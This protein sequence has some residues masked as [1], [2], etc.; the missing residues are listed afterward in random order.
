M[1]ET[2]LNQLHP[3]PQFTREAWQLLDGQWKFA[4][5][6]AGLGEVKNWQEGIEATHDILVPF[7]Y[8]TTLSGINIK[9]HHDV[10]WYE[11]TIDVT[12]DKSVLLHFEGVD[13]QATLWVNGKH[14][15]VHEG[16]YH[17]F[18]F[19][20][21]KFVTK[22]ENKVVLKVEDSKDCTQPRGKQRWLDDN[23][24]CWYVQTT[25]IW[26]SVWLEY[27]SEVHIEYVKMTP[28][29]NNQQII[30]EIELN[31]FNSKGIEVEAEITFAGEPINDVRTKFSGDTAKIVS[32]VLINGDPWSMKRWE[33]HEPNL[34]DVKFNLYKDG[35]L[36]DEVDSYFGMRKISI[37]GQKILLNDVE[38]YQ[39]SI[40]DQGY[41]LESDL[42]PP[43]VEALERDIDFMLEMGYNSV[44]KHQKIEDNRFLYLCDKKGL[45]VWSEFPAAYTFSDKAIER[46]TTEWMKILKQHYNHPSIITWV[47]FNESWGVSDI[48]NDKKQ[49]QFTESVYY[50]TKAFD[51]MRPVV[52]NDGWEHTITDIVTLH[53]YEELGHVIKERYSDEAHVL[54]NDIQHNEHRH[55]FAKGYGYTGQPVIMSEF[56][57][58]A[59]KSEDGWGY[60]NQVAS[61]EDF[62]D[63]FDK[64]H[65]AIQELGYISGFCYTQLTD[66]QQ[67]VNG[68]LTMDRKPKVDLKAIRKINTRRLKG[69]VKP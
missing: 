38:L 51:H 40:L 20:I 54:S 23:F 43:S 22:G 24:G 37:E 36:I 47:P 16:G 46:M 5:D 11:R 69:V 3:R 66:V 31:R 39:R 1:K 21:T 59:F 13:Y 56:G 48:L 64:V 29:Y 45:L 41:W 55:P 65:L 53:D 35:I 9:E 18:K 2:Q 50:L 25:G 61:E 14:V 68:L 60:G 6:D 26:K 67:E 42:T 27:V 7:T 10:V 8:E 52:S 49:Q 17:A 19:D 62:M 44:R 28:D 33:T 63:R 15:G 32:S 57:G 4:F 34:Y 30:F 58:I 12:S